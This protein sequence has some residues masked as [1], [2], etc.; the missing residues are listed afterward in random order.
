MR[1]LLRGLYPHAGVTTLALNLAARLSCM[2]GEVLYLSLQGYDAGRDALLNLP[3]DFKHETAS[4]GRKVSND[5]LQVTPHLFVDLATRERFIEAPQEFTAWLGRLDYTHLIIDA[6]AF[7]RDDAWLNAAIKKGLDD[8]LNHV[9]TLCDPDMG[10]LLTLTRLF[11]K[12][13]GEIVFNRFSPS[14][15]ALNDLYEAAFMVLGEEKL[16]PVPLP[17]DEELTLSSLKGEILA[18]QNPHAPYVTALGSLIKLLKT[19]PVTPG[20][21]L[22]ADAS[23]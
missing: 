23:A 3:L 4:P 20:E 12:P 22:R 17:Y 14:S 6:G 11:P 15:P 18:L 5:V 10:S 7:V 9:I 1:I 16:L 13:V 8:P 21:R 19:K 2:D